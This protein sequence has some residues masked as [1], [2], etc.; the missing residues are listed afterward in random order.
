M[1][2]ERQEGIA[3]E[4]QE[5]A[6]NIARISFSLRFH[7]QVWLPSL[8]YSTR[9]LECLLSD[10]IHILLTLEKTSGSV[11]LVLEACT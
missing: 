3:K 2:Q 5:Q 4:N 9:S 6:T 10:S 1:G 7:L 8:L 11:P